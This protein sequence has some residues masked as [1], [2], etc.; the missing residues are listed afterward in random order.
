VNRDRC[1]YPRWQPS[2]ENPA[3]DCFITPATHAAPLGQTGRFIALCVGCS[4]H[5]PDA[6]PIDQVEEP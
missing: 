1:Q 6:V 4:A 3:G 5:R 2:K